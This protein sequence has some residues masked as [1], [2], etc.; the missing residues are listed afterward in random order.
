MRRLGG[1]ALGIGIAAVASTGAV[2]AAF[3]GVPGMGSLRLA[4][5]SAVVLLGIAV[6]SLRRLPASLRQ[7][8]AIGTLLV[9]AWWAVALWPASP[10]PLPDLPR[11]HHWT[12]STGSQIAYLRLPATVRTPG[13]APVLMLHG[14]PGISEMTELKDFAESLPTRLSDYVI[15]DEVGAGRSSRLSDPDDYGIDR[16]VADLEAIRRALQSDRITLVGHSYGGVLA[17]A[18]AA[19]YP[20]RVDRM[21]LVSPGP[22][23]P[24]DRSMSLAR[25]RLSTG[26]AVTLYGVALSPRPLLVYTL[27]RADLTRAHQVFP[28]EQADPTNDDLLRRSANALYCDAP[29]DPPQGPSG[30]Y[31]LQ[32]GQGPLTPARSRQLEAGLERVPAPTLIIKGS[33]DYLSWDSA[34]QY[35]RAL[36]HAEIA[37][38]DGAGH[39]ALGERGDVIPGL[40]AG[41]INRGV[42]SGALE[43][44]SQPPS[45]QGPAVG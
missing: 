30:F 25:S 2:G 23:S 28:D 37:Y 18:Y 22:I 20:A 32:A 8:L 11:A 36:P 10:S 29:T 44:A 35:R 16:D 38:V 39:N 17:A 43:V 12:L 19:R 9:A 13:R 40:V 4:A 42:T 21:V 31:R 5:G 34:L 27:S 7:G 1:R 33:C 6:A 14:G 41:F 26:E 45:Y 15:Y 24:D 3:L